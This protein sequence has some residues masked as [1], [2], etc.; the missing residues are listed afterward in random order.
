MSAMT[1]D[2]QRYAGQLELT[3]QARAVAHRPDHD[4]IGRRHP[5]PT[6]TKAPPIGAMAPPGVPG[7]SCAA[8]IEGGR[9][10]T[11]EHFVSIRL[12]DIGT[13]EGVLTQGA[14][15][16]LQRLR[17]AHFEGARSLGIQLPAL[18]PGTIGA[19]RGGV[20]GDRDGADQNER[21][22]CPE[23]EEDAPVKRVHGVR[24]ARAPSALRSGSNVSA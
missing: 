23:S 8:G 9:Q 21:E 15:P 19:V 3:E 5:G 12:H 20:H 2:R 10:R 7:A 17:T 22:R 4:V 13:A 16:P 18:H 11:P 24:P 6:S 1:Q 14:Q